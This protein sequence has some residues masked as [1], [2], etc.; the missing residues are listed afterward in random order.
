MHV[1]RKENVC[2]ALPMFI[3]L[4]PDYA[5]SAAFRSGPIGAVN[6]FNQE[7]WFFDIKLLMSNMMFFNIYIY[8]WNQV[9][10]KREI[11]INI[12]SCVYILMFK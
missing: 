4:G 3:F 1:K 5:L 9:K 11:D 6:M 7:K 8:F 2:I 10:S 12:Y